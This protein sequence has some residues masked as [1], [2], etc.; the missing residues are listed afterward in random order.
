M[1]PLGSLCSGYGGLDIAANALFGSQTV[2]Y[3]DNAKSPTRVHEHHWPDLPNLGDVRAVEWSCIDAVEILTAGYPCQP[4]SRAGLK[5][6]VTD[7]RHLWPAIAEGVRVLRPGFVVLENVAGHRS[8]GL[9]D[10][11]GDL[12]ALG[13]R[14]AWGSVR[15]SDIG[16]PHMRERL[17]V[18]A[19]N[20]TGEDVRSRLREIESRGL[21]RGRPRDSRGEARARSDF[22]WG[23]YE[24]AIARWEDELDRRAPYPTVPGPLGGQRL[25]PVF[26]EWMMGLPEG[27]ITSVP[28]ISITQALKL[29]G[30]GVLPLQAMAAIH[31]LLEVLT[32][33]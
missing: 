4:F 8:R 19:T 11:L 26:A 9:G 16:A 12:A 33:P 13:Y 22:D 21:G 24:A 30:N 20:T 28:G 3:A 23:R 27:H 1:I 6:G 7:E 2:W 15:A 32:C 18:V 25:S 10:V 31:T 17:F 5:M 29:A 14:I